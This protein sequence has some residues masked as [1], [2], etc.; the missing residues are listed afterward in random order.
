MATNLKI[1]DS[2]LKEAL[3]LSGFRTKREAVTQALVEFVERRRQRKILKFEGKFDFDPEFDYKDQR[4]R[5]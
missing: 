2:L 3:E 5:A 4:R 1:D